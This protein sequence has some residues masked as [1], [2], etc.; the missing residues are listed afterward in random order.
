MPDGIPSPELAL[1]KR[2]SQNT[3]F[4]TASNNA[5]QDPSKPNYTSD[6]YISM[7]ENWTLMEDVDGGTNA[8]RAKCATYMPQMPLEHVDDYRQRVKACEFFAATSRTVRGLVGMVFRRPPKL[9]QE[10]NEQLAQHW[11]DIDGQ[12]THGEVFTRELYEQGMLLGHGVILVD[13]P[14]INPQLKLTLY[15]ERDAGVRPYWCAITPSQILNWRTITRYGRT[16]LQQVVIRECTLEPSGAFGEQEVERYR[17]FRLVDVYDEATKATTTQVQWSVWEWVESNGKR[18]LQEKSQGQ[19]M[20]AGGKPMTRIPVTAFFCG[21][22]KGWFESTPPLVDLAWANIAHWNVQSDHRHSLHKASIPLLVGIG[23]DT[24]EAAPPIGVNAMIDMPIGGD[25]KYVEHSG[26]ALSATAQELKDLETRM[27]ALGL[28][29]LQ[30]ESRAAETARARR[31]DKSEQD[32][33][34]ANSARSLQ[35]AIEEALSY[36]SEYLGLPPAGES[37]VLVNN[38]FEDLT[39][40]PTL[41]SAVSAL[42]LAGQI[43]LDTLWSILEENNA[44]PDDFDRETVRN[45]IMTEEADR[46]AQALALATAAP[47]P[48]DDSGNPVATDKTKKPPADDTS[49]TK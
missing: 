7:R 42:H 35:D 1:A 17:V 26:S 21:P 13:Y 30:S 25:L 22:K 43:D 32:S 9:G 48:V 39:P 44:L 27:A 19:M 16:M 45:A 20:V 49:V 31:I 15:D 29:M 38:D 12:G 34:L 8:M 33:A 37:S 47:T 5:P 46:A 36:H 3:S 6:A 10:L 23:R 40:E 18:E 41:I 24:S 4:L 11:E 28:A 2:V 14:E